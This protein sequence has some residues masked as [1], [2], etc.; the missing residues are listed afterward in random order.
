MAEQ[1]LATKPDNPSLNPRTNKVVEKTPLP[2]VVLL[3]AV[4]NAVNANYR[5][6]FNKNSNRFFFH[7]I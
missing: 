4:V 5:F 6:N 3:H 7:K 1:A 2:Q